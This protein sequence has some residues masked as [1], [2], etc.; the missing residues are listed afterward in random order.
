MAVTAMD[1]ARYM[2]ARMAPGYQHL[3]TVMA[4][5]GWRSGKP[6][7]VHR[8]PRMFF[9]EI[10]QYRWEVKRS[11]QGLWRVRRGREV[12]LPRIGWIVQYDWFVGAPVFESPVAAALWFDRIG[13][14]LLKH[15]IW[16]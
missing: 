8:L 4:E 6:T 16:A 11:P 9:R 13:T 7:N 2:G 1:R 10:G 3:P 15:G 14:A 5:L 12:L